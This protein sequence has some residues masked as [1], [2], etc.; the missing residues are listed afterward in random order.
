MRTNTTTTSTKRPV[1]SKAAAK[2]TAVKKVATKPDAIALLKDD[3]KRVKKLFKDFEKIKDKAEA[4]EKEALVTQICT[5]LTIHTQIE[6]EIFYPAVRKA[7]DES[8]LLDEAEVE[9]A[10]AK[11]LIKQLQGMSVS[12]PLYD[13]KVKV[14]GEY[15]DHH[16]QEE[17]DEMFKK[18]KKAKVDME[19]LGKKM[20]TRKRA[21]LKEAQLQ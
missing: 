3:H 21:L 15:V 12:E 14:L 17:Q 1:A 4:T 2:T 5:E 18:A 16:V 8:D 6:E 7:I 11:D 20:A 9:H 10:S 13:A 19:K